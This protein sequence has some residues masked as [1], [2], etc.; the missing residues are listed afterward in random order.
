MICHN[1]LTCSKFRST[2]YYKKNSEKH[3]LIPRNV[4]IIHLFSGG[5]KQITASIV[6]KILQKVFKSKK[7]KTKQLK[8]SK[9]P[10]HELLC[11]RNNFPKQSQRSKQHSANCQQFFF[12][13]IGL[14]FS[15]FFGFLKKGYKLRHIH[16]ILIEK[17][18]R[19]M[20]VRELFDGLKKEDETVTEEEQR[21]Q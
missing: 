10:Q 18:F 14:L 3:K 1:C 7:K 6:Q 4:I 8:L 13:L 2:A 12:F 21:K 11:S 20:A 19:K 17:T 9:Y 5:I 15:F 16:L